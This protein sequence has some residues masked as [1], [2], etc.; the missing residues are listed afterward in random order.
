MRERCEEPH[1]RDLL[2]DPLTGIVMA[3]DGVSRAE[4]VR[5]MT[6]IA[7]RRMSGSPMPLVPSR[8][9]R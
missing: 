8:D 7:A 1:L 2:E 4:L 3:R 5:L 6:R 9:P